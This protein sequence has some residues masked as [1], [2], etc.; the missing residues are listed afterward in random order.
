MLSYGL[1]WQHRT[2]QHVKF[3]CTLLLD[4]NFSLT[5]QLFD[6]ESKSYNVS[7]KGIHFNFA[8]KSQQRLQVMAADIKPPSYA[9][10]GRKKR[11]RQKLTMS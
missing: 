9:Y 2:E 10:P 5:L 1:H 4:T 7:I 6:A 11:S 3:C 8:T